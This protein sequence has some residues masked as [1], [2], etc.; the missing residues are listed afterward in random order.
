M[1]AKL[2]VTWVRSALTVQVPS[3]G[4]VTLP[5]STSS[6]AGSRSSRATVVAFEGPALAIVSAYVIEAPA[7]TGPDEVV[8]V[9]TRCAACVTGVVA[10]A[11]LLPGTGSGVAAPTF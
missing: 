10:V 5:G 8:F 3:A 4:A 7:A 2:H 9:R 6:P 1:V 11:E